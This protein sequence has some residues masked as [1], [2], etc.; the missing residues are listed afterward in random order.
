VVDIV[1]RAYFAE[2]HKDI[3]AY[4]GL[5]ITNCIVLG[6]LEA[7]ASRN[8]PL[9]SFADGLGAGLGYSLLL[10]A[11]AIVREVLGFGTLF[12]WDIPLAGQT[13][14]QWMRQSNGQFVIMIMPP[15]AFFVLA[16]MV[17]VARST[18]IRREARQA[19]AQGGAK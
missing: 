8:R 3:A 5:I 7:F 9:A 16:I 10:M 17:W 18:A 2:V 15:G 13:L 12:G 19:A 6:R 11:V 4:V 1:L 14:A